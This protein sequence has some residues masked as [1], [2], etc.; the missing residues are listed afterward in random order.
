MKIVLITQNAPMYLATFL[1]IFLFRINKTKHAVE[2]IVV[3]SPTSG[4]S[5]LKEL[6]RRYNYYGFIDFIKMLH[7]VMRN[8]L[9]SFFFYIYPISTCYS[10]NNV[11]KK[12]GLKKILTESINSSR[13]IK[14]IKINQI[15]LIVSIAAP[16]IFKQEVLSAPQ[17]GCINYHSA[18]LPK[19]RGRQPLFWALLNDEKEVGISIHEMDDKIDNGPIISQNKINVY[20][21]DTLHSLYLKTIKIGPT[22]LLEAIKKLDNDCGERIANDAHR[23]SYY[24]F[25]TKKEARLFKEKGKRIFNV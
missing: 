18:I 23:A 25:P 13:F 21:Q 14:Y 11:I 22:L 8:K 24:N 6:S 12:Y 16:E 17:K 5:V 2:N 9:F 10:V 4:T 15:D 7:H 19:Y 3:L 20:P 1:D